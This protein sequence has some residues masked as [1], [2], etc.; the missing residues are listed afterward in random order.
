MVVL[1]AMQDCFAVCPLLFDMRACVLF[2]FLSGFFSFICPGFDF[3]R[4]FHVY[5]PCH[6][7][8]SARNHPGFTL[9]MLSFFWW[10]LLI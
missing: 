10:I 3:L 5:S 7:R 4:W 1:D 9:Q 2:C 8:M 6:A